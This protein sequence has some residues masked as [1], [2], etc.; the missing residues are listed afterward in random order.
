MSEQFEQGLEILDSTGILESAIS[1]KTDVDYSS[2]W[3]STDK[4]LFIGEHHTKPAEEKEFLENMDGFKTQGAT[5]IGLEM[6]QSDIQ[7]LL[8][9][10][11]AESGR[12]SLT[13]LK[14]KMYL[15]KYWGEYGSEGVDGYMKI[16]EKAK[17]LGLKIVA[18][19]MP[20]EGDTTTP[21]AMKMRNVY[22]ADTLSKVIEA[23][24]E[25]RIVALGGDEHL[26]Y[27]KPEPSVNELLLQKGIP[28]TSL[29]LL[30]GEKRLEGSSQ[31][32]ESKIYDLVKKGNLE[33][34]RFSLDVRKLP[35]ARNAD[36]YVH[37]PQVG[38]PGIA[39]ILFK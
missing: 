3:S 22:W 18:F 16:V 24:P 34:S 28:S 38:M 26:G 15:N 4:V 11:M 30:G 39:K 36:Y 27:K 21:E 8:D 1:E 32:E 29:I 31:D 19:D 12:V 25:A 23:D 17:S 5:H 2:M 20:M 14:L 6:F 37:M 33:K 9:M 13:S 10:Y 7:P 35:G